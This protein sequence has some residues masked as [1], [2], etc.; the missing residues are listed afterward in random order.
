VTPS[1]VAN[2]GQPAGWRPVAFREAAHVQFNFALIY[3]G[4]G[5]YTGQTLSGVTY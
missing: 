3:S 1:T 5:F 4:D 2:A